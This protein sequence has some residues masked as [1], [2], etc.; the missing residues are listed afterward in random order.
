MLCTTT[1]AC[2]DDT[3]TSAPKATALSNA[4]K[5]RA[6]VAA[7]ESGDTTALDHVS[8][9]YLQHNLA[10]PDG[11]GVLSGFFTGEA[12]GIIATTHRTFTDGDIVFMHNEYGGAWNEGTP[13]IAFDVF[14]FDGE[15][16]IAEHWD[17]LADVT[18]DMDGTTQTDGPTVV[19]DAAATEANRAVVQGAL[20]DLFIDGRWSTIDT[21]FDLDRYVQHSVGFGPDATGL[22]TVLGSLP[23][24]TPFYSSV[25]Y[26]HVEGDFALTL[27]EGFPNMETGLADAYY[28]LFRLADGKIVEHWD[29][30]QTIP[31]EA[32]WANSNGKW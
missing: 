2:S 13:Q 19:S 15:G 16:L 8:D 25:E 18:D 20:Q 4:E 3:E 27:S 14:R 21:Y 1:V 31:A 23:D 17:N 11:K 28:D 5:A 29:I 22:Q 12:T 30:I 32:D 10:F 6:L 26:V 9:T 24:G 7:F